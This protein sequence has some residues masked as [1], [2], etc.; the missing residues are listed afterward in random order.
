MFDPDRI[1]PGRVET[2]YDL[3][4]GA[5]RLYGEAT[6]IEHVF[7]AGI[8]VVTG[9]AYTGATPGRVLRSGYDTR[10]VTAR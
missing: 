4:A 5:G 8:E 7:V 6:G 10:T 3:P 2:R 9:N 1:G